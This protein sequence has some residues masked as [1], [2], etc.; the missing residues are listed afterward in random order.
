MNR[1]VLEPLRKYDTE[2]YWADSKAFILLTDEFVSYYFRNYLQHE[3]IAVDISKS[4]SGRFQLQRVS[5]DVLYKTRKNTLWR[6]FTWNARKIQVFRLAY[7]WRK[8]S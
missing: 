2:W 5:D 7:E 6:K 4:E 3:V 1:L 8:K